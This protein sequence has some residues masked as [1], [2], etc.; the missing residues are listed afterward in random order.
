[1]QLLTHFIGTCNGLGSLV[2]HYLD[3]FIIIGAP[4]SPQCEHSLAI[5]DEICAALDIPMA[6]HKREGPT[7]CIVILGIEVS[8]AS[9]LTSSAGYVPFYTNGAI[10][11][12]VL[13][14]NSN[15]SL[16]S[17]IILAKWSST[18]AYDKVH[19]SGS[20]PSLML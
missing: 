20:M 5:L 6:A 17:S 9:Q 10:R 13:A 8:C 19:S 1:M 18:D 16:A 11:Q 14:K 3:D 12:L 7:T 4:L 2:F 15:P